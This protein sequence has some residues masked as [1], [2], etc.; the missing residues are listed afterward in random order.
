[1]IPSTRAVPIDCVPPQIKQRSRLHWWLAEQE[2]RQTDAD[3]SA[4]LLNHQGHITETAAANFLMVKNGIVFCPDQR[5][6]LPGVSQKVVEELCH[7]LNIPFVHRS[8]TVAD[9]VNADEA[10]LTCTSFCLAGVSK[11]NGKAL[12]W[13]G[14]IFEQ[15]LDH[16]SAKIGL[17]IQRQIMGD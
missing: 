13:P 2:A 9:A 5:D 1:M 6:V 4:L 8:L 17:D 7:E 10:M 3:A 14:K 16:W 12:H 11:I 15:L